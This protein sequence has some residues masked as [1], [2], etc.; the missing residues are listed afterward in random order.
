MN[1]HKKSPTGNPDVIVVGSGFGGSVT[2]AR[3]AQKGMKVLILER[4]PWWGQH[5]KH[6]NDSTHR[7]YPRG[8]LGSRKFLRSIRTSQNGITQ[9]KLKNYDGLLEVHKFQNLTT[10]TSSAVGGGSHIYTNIMDVADAD[11]FESYPG[12]ITFEEMKKY[13][14]K[15]HDVLN[16]KPIPD[17]PHKNQIFE[18]AVKHAGL[19]QV[20]YPEL[21]IAW[22]KDPENPVKVKNSAG[23]T[24][25][26]STYQNDF[27][28]GSEDGSKTSMDVTYI[29]IA[30]QNDAELRPLC[31][32]Q[33]IE[34]TQNGY[35]VNYYD[36]LSGGKYHE[37]A[38]R[39]VLA[40]GSL[41]TQRLLFRARDRHKTLPQISDQLGRNFSPNGDLAML[42]LKTRKLKDSSYGTS[43]NAYTRIQE[44][45]SFRYLIGEVGLP[46]HVIPLPWPI[47]AWLKK[48]TYLF[49]M[50]RDASDGTIDFD[51][52]EL[53]TSVDRSIDEEL[54]TAM[55][56]SMAQIAKYYQPK[57][58]KSREGLFSVHPMG[59]CA[60][61]NTKA[62][63]VVNHK[64]EVYGHPGLYIADGS[65]YPKAPGIAPSMTIAALAERLAD[66]MN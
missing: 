1:I 6:R 31:E 23:I 35:R 44:N 57:R 19:P 27:L 63:G 5:N 18:Q 45:N 9:E 12:E 17:K 7:D 32:V 61:G 64:G 50:G 2:A 41:N 40:A 42:L 48:S 58:V 8:L 13:Y 56:T 24:Q 66:L 25:S 60:I 16:P 10:I 37:V 43:F 20:E 36:H 59:G 52:K 39:V 33:S 21:A 29:P 47:S 28:V 38:A 30:L 34:P 53:K 14:E 55:E 4:G 54:Y 22:G 26:T 65:L 11:H 15:V 49:A 46:V 62:D 3:L 51:G